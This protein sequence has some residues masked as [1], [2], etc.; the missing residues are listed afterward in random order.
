MRVSKTST[1]ILGVAL[2][3]ALVL[4]LMALAAQPVLAGPLTGFSHSVDKPYA[5][6]T[7]THTI[8]FTIASALPA[9]G[10]IRITFPNGFDVSVT[11]GDVKVKVGGSNI[12]GGFTVS[13]EGQTIIIARDGT[14]SQLNAD[15][16]IEVEI[17][18][19]VNTT[20]SGEYYVTVG[21]WF[22]GWIDGPTD[23]DDTFEI[24]PSAEFD[25]NK[26]PCGTTTT[27]SGCGWGEDEPI[28]GVW[29]GGQPAAHTLSVD[30]SGALSGTITV[31]T[32]LEAGDKDIIIKGGTSDNQTFSNAFEVTTATATFNPN[33]GPAGTLANVSGTGWAP[34][35]TIS[36][37]KVGGSTA[38]HT[39]TV[40]NTG[41][42]SGTV[43]IPAGLGN[44]VMTA[45]ITGTKS[46][47]QTINTAF[48]VTTATATFA[49]DSGP[50]GTVTTV[51]GAGWA[52]GDTITAV[53]VGGKSATH[54][55]TVNASGD[56]SGTITIPATLSTGAKNVVIT[57]AHSGARTFTN[58]FT[59]TSA[60]TAT[61]SPA[62]A[63]KSDL[64]KTVTVSG[65]GW[66]PS[67]NITR[68][69]VGGVA[70]TSVSLSVNASGALSG[71][72]QVP[73]TVP[74]GTH[75]VVITG[76]KTGVQ[77]FANAFKVLME[78][79]LCQGWNL[80][81]LPLIPNSTAIATVLADI[82][83]NVESVWYYSGGTWKTWSPGV[84]GNLTT[85]ED[86]KAYW[87]KMVQAATLEVEGR[88]VPEP[89]TAP[90]TY[91]LSVGWN[92]LGYKSTIERKT[93]NSG[94]PLGYLNNI[95]GKYSYLVTYDCTQSN[96]WQELHLEN[97]VMKPG[98][99]YWIY[100][101][102]AGSIPAPTE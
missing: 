40:N 8:G 72:F 49:P 91:S 46:G 57:G 37:V 97:G 80:I 81:S 9:A 56:L 43:T 36:Q 47:T 18:N 42:L 16:Q 59:V 10:Q 39:L 48:T 1:N 98:L 14:G 52:L 84:G 28:M 41:A 90:P 93:I 21:T 88:T 7:A 34:S 53:T 5:G 45:L 77:T 74:P 76:E 101:T 58:A 82:S 50:V 86:G 30:S 26:G 62:S 13:I 100:M 24:L 99:G 15:S 94:T 11:T 63:A 4:S 38:S 54:T 83:E 35:D 6:A 79:E 33:K 102:T 51:S 19:I 27:V 64:P 12:S 85:M 61:F 25:P 29:V 66:V 65:S 87:V 89:P 78:I 32:G 73:N 67:D 22:G 2:S 95:A 3:L 17:K 55:L 23:S 69:T 92:M 31:P 44:G 96:P 20:V 68:V 60:P 71:T 75:N 70:A